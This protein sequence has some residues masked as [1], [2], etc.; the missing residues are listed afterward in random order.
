MSI[1]RSLEVFLLP[2][3]TL[4]LKLVFDNIRNYFICGGLL[5]MV[6]WFQSGKATAPPV[7][8]KAP[9]ADGWQLLTWTTLLTTG[10]LFCLNVYQSYLLFRR[11]MKFL[12]D[13]PNTK[14]ISTAQEGNKVAWYIYFIAYSFAIIAT[15][16]FITIFFVLF[17]LVLYLPWFASAASR[18]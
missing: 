7:V 5:G 16:A 18:S 17:Q 10:I 12:D 8:F 4:S 11:P 13:Q 1:R 6:F 9:P 14:N 15:L 2:E 3:S